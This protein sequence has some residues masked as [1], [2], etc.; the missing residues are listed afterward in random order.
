MNN[1]KDPTYDFSISSSIWDKTDDDGSDQ[2][3][4]W[5]KKSL[6]LRTKVNLKKGWTTNFFSKFMD[7]KKSQELNIH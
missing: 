3:V 5:A 1:R 6:S 7:S 2:T 4:D